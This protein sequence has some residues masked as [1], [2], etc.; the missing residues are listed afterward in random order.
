MMSMSVTERERRRLVSVASEYEQMGYEV[1]LQPTAGDLPEFL[2]GF[3]PDL[4]AIGN[5]ESVVGEVKAR[6]EF[7]N[8]QAVAAAIEAALRN[9]PGWRFELIIDGSESEDGRLLGAPQIGTSLEEANELQQ[10]GHVVA[11][12]LLMWSATEGILRLLAARENV[13]LESPAPG[14]MTKRLY[15]LGLLG[16]DQ[17]R[18]LDE[19]VRLRNQA[20]HGFRVA[21]TREDL[22]NVATIARELL[23]ELESKAA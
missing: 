21:V 17:Y 20:A 4:I 14:Y 5:G 11:A 16:R 23:S 3:E 15:T 7:E 8:E 9:R 19:A 6:N 22:A 10:R 2:V 12:L 18:I 1:K 13:E